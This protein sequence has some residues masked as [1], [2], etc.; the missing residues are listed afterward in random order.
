MNTQ[1][2]AIDLDGTLFDAQGRI[3]QANV[4]A[5]HRAQ[6][7]GVRVALCTGRGLT[8]SQSA[9][10]ALGF[11]G[12]LVLANGALIADAESRQT[13][14]RATIEPHVM[15]DIIDTLNNGRDAVLIL[16]DPAHAARDYLIVRADLLSKNTLWWFDYCNATFTPNDHPTESD[17]HHAVRAGIVGPADHM[18]P[19]Q[20]RIEQTFGPSVFC[21]HFMAVDATEPD[22]QP[23][24][25]L[26]VFTAGVNKWTA[27]KWLAECHNIEPQNIAAIGDHI[28]DIDMITHAGKGIAMANAVPTILAA[29]NHTTASNTENGVAHAIDQLLSGAW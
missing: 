29:A 25:V 1:L 18:P 11:T 14:E 21:Q 10:N 15:I 23:T 4:D 9:I 3:S 24:H 2:L 26:E 13:L 12:T 16:L 27:L 7:A 28:N 17:L 19:V 20:Q 22:G 6:N 8:E 5:V